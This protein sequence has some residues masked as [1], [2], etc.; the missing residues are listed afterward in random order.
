[1]DLKSNTIRKRKF[2]SSRHSKTIT[3]NYWKQHWK[4][5][6]SSLS[7][8]GL[9]R[10]KLTTSLKK[11]F[12]IN[13]PGNLV[14]KSAFS[15]N[16][17]RD[18]FTLKHTKKERTSTWCNI[19]RTMSWRYKTVLVR[20]R[21]SERVIDHSRRN[22][23]SHISKHCVEKEHK[24]LHMDISILCTNYGK[25]KFRSKTAESLFI[26]ERVLSDPPVVTRMWS[27]KVI[28]TNLSCTA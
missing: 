19:L 16:R 11:S 28:W 12:K 4:I 6:T 24:P 18:R 2:K 22:K 5:P 20:R 17:L 15:A 7:Y 25:N 23:Y 21:L 9:K 10:D 3:S 26:K 13:F 14:T 1:M 8:A 27:L